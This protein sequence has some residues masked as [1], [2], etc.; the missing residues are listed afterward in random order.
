[1]LRT[2]HVSNPMLWS[3]YS[4]QNTVGQYVIFTCTSR[5]VDAACSSSCPQS[6]SRRRE[7]EPVEIDPFHADDAIAKDVAIVWTR[8][9]PRGKGHNFIKLQPQEKE[10]ETGQRIRSTWHL[11]MR[12][13]RSRPAGEMTMVHRGVRRQRKRNH[14]R[15]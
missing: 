7:I 6:S 3:L 8:G 12:R 15:A 4:A 13:Q 1:M 10:S 11:G 2:E 5:P 14:A 9:C